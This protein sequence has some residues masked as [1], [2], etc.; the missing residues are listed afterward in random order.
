MSGTICRT[1]AVVNARV[2]PRLRYFNHLIR[3][4]QQRRRDREA[5]RLGGLQ[6]DDQFEIPS[7][8]FVRLRA[9]GL[10]SSLPP[11]FVTA[12]A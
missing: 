2:Q 5:E 7:S 10:V 12:L 6:V 8:K 4:Q 9:P 3:P 11:C 1:S